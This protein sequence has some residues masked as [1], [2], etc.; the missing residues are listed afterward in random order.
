[1]SENALL[2]LS[3]VH[4]SDLYLNM[5][6]LLLLI[7]PT[8][9]PMTWRTPEARTLHYHPFTS[10]EDALAGIARLRKRLEDAC[11]NC[12]KELV[13]KPNLP[14][15]SKHAELF[16]HLRLTVHVQID[17]LLPCHCNRKMYY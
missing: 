3:T 13:L 2:P 8:T 10:Y 17:D 5:Q 15:N 1:M 14:F 12:I 4:L 11:V 7:S 9:W 6:P 16:T